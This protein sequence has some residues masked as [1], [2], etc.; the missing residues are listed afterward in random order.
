MSRFSADWLALREPADIRA[1]RGALVSRLRR[2]WAATRSGCW[3]TTTS[4]CWRPLSPRF[5]HGRRVSDGSWKLVVR[6]SRSGVL[7][8][9]AVYGDSDSTLPKTSIVST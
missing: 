5:E 4:H 2:V 3:S 7:V 8:Y 9:T 6:R 1:S